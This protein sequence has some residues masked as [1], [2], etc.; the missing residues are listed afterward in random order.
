MRPSSAEPDLSIVIVSWNTCEIL[1]DCLKTVR[2]G[3]GGLAAEV[4]IVDNASKDDSAAMVERE[5]PEFHLLRMERNLGFAGG[6]NVAL[7]EARG[8]HVLLLNSDTLVLGDVLS[9][10]MAWLDAHPRV[11]VMGC[12]VVNADRT[13]QSTCFQDPSLVNLLL[14]A[15][16][17][18][19]LRWP[20]FFGR[21]QMRH[22]GRDDEREVDVVTGCFMLVRRLA[23]DAVGLLDDTFFFCAEEADW[24]LRFRRAGWGV[25]F[26][27]EIGRASCRERV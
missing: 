5:F 16:F 23:M 1:R 22:W 7:R 25:M 12:R 20:R 15:L 4:F 11:A 27:P 10:C 2:D 14:D 18:S 13:T 6:N 3:L 26:A 19:S 24:C 17:L 9:C 21:Y 8:R